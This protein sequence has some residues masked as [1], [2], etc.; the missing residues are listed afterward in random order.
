MNRDTTRTWLAIALGWAAIFIAIT[1]FRPLMPVD[2]TRYMS[3]A[4]EM[5]VRDT[6]LLPTLNYEPYSHKPPLL[7]WLIRASWEIFGV[8]VAP[9]RAVLG[10]FILALFAL[11]AKLAQDIL[12]KHDQLPSRSMMMLA[13][14]P[15]FL[16]YASMIMFDSLLTVFVLCGLLAIWHASQKGGAWTWIALGGAIGFGILA[17]GPVAL[18]YILPAA[19]LAPLW[20]PA[21]SWKKWY[22]GI[23]ISVLIGAAIALSWAIPA[24]IEGGDAYAQKI[25]LKQSAGRMVNAFDHQQPFWF[26]FPVVLSFLA[27]LALWPAF[28]A[29]MRAKAKNLLSESDDNRRAVKFLLCQIVPVFL[30]F[31]LISSKQIH[32]MVPLLPAACVLLALLLSKN[33]KGWA[34]GLPI[35]ASA[36]PSLIL[37]CDY[38]SMRITGIEIKHWD[39]IMDGF[40]PWVAGTH[41]GLAVALGYFSERRPDQGFRAM[42]VSAFMLMIFVHIQLGQSFFPRYDLSPLRHTMEQYA[43]RPIAAAPKYDGE[44]GYVLRLE[45]HLDLV[46][47][48]TIDPWI[49]E[50]KNGLVIIRDDGVPDHGLFYSIYHSQMYRFNK[51]IAV[52]GW[53]E[54]KYPYWLK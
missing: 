14:L 11:T 33:S 34:A 43:D 29:G 23:G 46:E 9:A 13:A 39:H 6:W 27:P 31:T 19:L 22:G 24:A 10:V 8:K 52:I 38:W 18:I 35:V 20:T 21:T 26:Y 44:Y 30:F 53:N 17:K 50:H 48:P 3:V 12:P 47:G 25:F 54:K 49:K 42:A 32:Y 41:I 28:W 45:K 4:W 5:L 2:E 15:L 40:M 51:R 36:S 16:I 7:F 1:L 37:L